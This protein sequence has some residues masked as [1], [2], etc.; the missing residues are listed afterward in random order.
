[1]IVVDTVSY[2][3]VREQLFL[4]GANG[5]AFEKLLSRVGLSRA[6]VLIT[7]CCNQALPN[8]NINWLFDAKGTVRD[9]QT[10]MMN[11]LRL[12][13]EI[14]EHEPNVIVAMG[15]YALHLLTG[16]GHWQ[17]RK[18]KGEVIGW[19]GLADWRGS[20]IDGKGIAQGRKVVAVQ[21][22]ESVVAQWKLHAFWCADMLRVKEQAQFPEI[23]RH[24]RKLIIDPPAHELELLVQEMLASSEPISY[25]IEFYHGKLLCIGFC[26]SEAWS[27]TVS[28]TGASSMD[29]YSR[30]LQSGHA[31]AAQNA[32]FDCGVLEWHFGIP[33]FERLEYDTILASHAAY[34]ELPKDLGTLCSLYTEEPCYWDK[35][36]WSGLGKTWTFAEML[37]YNC[38]DAWVT[39]M[40]RI[41]QIRDDLPDKAVHA[42]FDFE[43]SLLEPLWDISSRGVPWSVEQVEKVRAEAQEGLAETQLVLDTFYP[44][45]EGGLNVSSSKQ[46][47]VVLY[48]QLGVNTDFGKSFNKTTKKHQERLTNDLV[49]ASIAT[50]PVH[51]KRPDIITTVSLIRKARKHRSMI[52]KFCGDGTE[53]SGIT[54]DDD[55]RFRSTYVPSGTTT[56]RLAAKQF[57][58]TGRGANAQNQP[59]DKE[60]R[61]CFVPDPGYVIAYNDLERAESF[62]VAKITGD[63]VML[64][65]HLPGKNAH[66]LLGATLFN[67]APEEL[68]AD[69]YYLSKKTRHAGNYMQGW[70]T[71]MNNVNKEA[72][73]TGVVLDAKMAKKLIGTYREM[74][75]G[76]GR[77]WDAVKYKLSQDRTLHNL[78]GRPR[79]FYG[80]V[81]AELPE[82]VAYTPQS[83]VGDC[84][85][86]GILNLWNAG[87]AKPVKKGGLGKI[88]MLMQIHDALVYQF[89][90]TNDEEM[91]ALLREVRQHMLIETTNPRDGE[92]FTINTMPAISHTSWG[93]CKE[94][95]AAE[96][97]LV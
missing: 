4:S 90:Y 1:M 84:M 88:Q 41:G 31:L 81:D 77:W 61:R 89:P 43:M 6:N 30:I 86:Y 44:G 57:F 82:A 7:S 94:L 64:D 9:Q 59:R 79:V 92:V 40:V 60:V 46:V 18:D 67:K 37:E 72:E 53:D 95:S 33:T 21:H 93:D 80:R 29:L 24:P 96:L 54:V 52:A 8:G 83:T 26:N 36:D 17:K 73:K 28:N 97:G 13:G 35:T 3:D 69:E 51:A 16:K 25:D 5:N 87:I 65:H 75:V 62:V 47:G 22:I 2:Q 91:Y 63:R 15:P 50:A 42:T 48:D 70:L 34:I 20:I 38:K 74:H 55:G 11:Y 10:Y 32:M 45:F 23:R 39:H 19:T 58:P 56:G 71:F 12:Y 49:L 68:D 14:E 66:R 85:N 76:L 78:Y 27:L